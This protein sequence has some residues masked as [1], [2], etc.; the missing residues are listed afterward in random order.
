[1]QQWDRDTSGRL[2]RIST[3]PDLASEVSVQTDTMDPI[4]EEQQSQPG[5][6]MN[7]NANRT[8]RDHIH[9]P[10]VSA[11]SC[12]VPPADDVAVRPYLVPLLPTYHGMENENPY[13]HLRDFEEVCTTFKEGMMDMDLLKLKA[14][15]LTLKD[16]AKIWL[17]SLR[18]RTIR[19][20]AELQAEFLKKF[21]SAHK[22]NNLKRQIYTFT[23]HEGEKFYQCWERFMEISN[24]CPHHGFDTWMLVNH[25]YD[26]MSPP[27]KQLVETMCGGNF[28]SK[29][30]DQAIDFLHY[31]VETSKAWDEPRPREDEG[32]RYPSN[33]GETIHTI[34][35]DTLIREKLII[36]TRRLDEME[37]KNQHNSY[38]INELSASQPSCYNHQSHGHYGENCQENVQILN[39]GRPPLNVPFGNPYIQN[40]KNH[41]NLPG[42]P[43]VP[44]TDQQQF[45]PTSQQQQPIS[46]SPVEQAVLNLSK[47]V[48]TIAKEQKVHLSNMQDEISKLSNQLLQSSEK[49]KGLFQ[50]QQYQNMVNEIGLTEDTT[51]RTDEVKAVVTLRSG[52]ELKTAVP[53]LIKS[54]PV[55]AEPLQEEQTIALIS[56]EESQEEEC[57]SGTMVEEPCP[58]QPQEGLV[59]NSESSDIGVVVCLWE[60]KD[61]I[62]LLLTEE[63][64]EEH[65]DNIFPLPPTDSVYILPLPAPQS[66]PKNNPL[67]VLPTADQVYI[68]PMPAAQ[69]KPAAPSPKAKSNPLHVVQ[70]FKELVASVHALATTSKTMATAYIAWHSGWFECG[71]GFGTPGP[72]HF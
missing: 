59:E 26:G 60:K 49:E 10:R 20:W 47:V 16:K 68:L 30:P 27:M 43:Y 4:P 50:G 38:S 40:W 44:P 57:Q 63:A 65:K 2:N 36:L 45:T 66:Q 58:Q 51:T 18:P 13:T 46:L 37:I 31:I 8:M 56:E 5:T 61:T 28:L 33:Q 3:Q 39:Q 35:E 17:N 12:I 21:F 9:P 11:P 25:F 19:D 32:L 52:R 48:D 7:P 70:N 62:P 55:G 69:P 41:S 22:T 42:K 72:R 71:F 53:E 67:L 15:P 29:H 64:V 34:S 14:F 6:P 54:A 1:M 24:A 23:A